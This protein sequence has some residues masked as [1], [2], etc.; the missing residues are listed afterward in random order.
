MGF[1]CNQFGEQE[2][3]TDAE[4]LEFV[5]S[6]FDVDFPMFSK[7]E[8]NGDGAAELY[9]W[10]KAEQ[11]GEGDGSEITWNFEKFLVNGRG[12]AVARFPPMMTP[13]EVDAQLGQYL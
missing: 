8:V 6:K 5:S 7:L 4:V 1:P 3:G 11:P 9:K 12:E 2:P 10:L 13:E